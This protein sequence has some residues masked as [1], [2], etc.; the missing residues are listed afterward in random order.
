MSRVLKV[1]GS[2]VIL[3][4]LLIFGGAGASAQ[5]APGVT[6]KEILIGSCS[7][8]EGPSHYLGTQQVTGAKAYLDMVN[9]AGGVEG[10]KL[11]LVTSDDS[12]DPA[13]TQE[14]F[15]KLLS[16]KVFAMGFFVGTPTAV[17]YLPLAESNKIP[18]VGLFTG[19]QTLYTPL[20]HWVI[21]VRASYF[22]E[23]R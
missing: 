10:R 14:C 17:K 6:E 20:R 4:T 13:K 2:G 22:D 16:Q 1:Y 7:A 5:T 19:A 9:E 3:A 12:Y 15:D 18:L 11:R 21:N 23:T 8:L